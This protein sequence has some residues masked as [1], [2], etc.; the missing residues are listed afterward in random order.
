MGPR[1]HLGAGLYGTAYKDWDDSLAHNKRHDNLELDGDRINRKLVFIGIGDLGYA[2]TVQDAAVGKHRYN[3]HDTDPRPWTAPELTTEKAFE[4]S[5]GQKYI[6]NWTKSTNVYAM[7]WLIRE[8]CGDFFI[9]VSRKEKLE[10]DREKWQN[11]LMVDPKICM[12]PIESTKRAAKH[13]DGPRD[14]KENKW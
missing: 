10:Y 4:G 7:G 11:Q 1:T 6:T 12:R 5:D 13:P 8:I 14:I 2:Q 9:D 3:F